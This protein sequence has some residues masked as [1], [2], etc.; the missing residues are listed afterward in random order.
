M[1]LLILS[2]LFLGVFTSETQKLGSSNNKFALQLFNE[3]FSAKKLK[4]ESNILFSP[5]SATAALCMTMLGAEGDTLSQM[6]DV[7]NMN[8]LENPHQVLKN[9]LAE[10]ENTDNTVSIANRLFGNIDF[11]FD[12]SFLD[13]TRDLYGAEMQRVDFSDAEVARGTI[14]D[15]VERKTG[16]KIQNL[17]PEGI[18]SETVALV[19][20]NAIYFQANWTDQFESEW[21]VDRPFYSS[22]RTSTVK[23]MHKGGS[24]NYVDDS[25]LNSEIIEMPFD[26]EVFSYYVILPHKDTHVKT[27]QDSLTHTNIANGIQSL[28]STTVDVALP[29]F[30][31]TESLGLKTIL[32]NM[33][34][35]DLFS[36][37]ADL[38]GIS[39]DDD[40]FVSDVLQKA[41]LKVMYS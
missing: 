6:K 39:N 9:L 19:L 26:G 23:M 33:G 20:T 25:T 32:E 22:G 29:K 14:N 4:D 24:Y 13:D 38:T 5:F 40:L 21:T 8:D 12:Q 2:A 34:M 30:E 1:R 37:N 31:V 16:N 10:I 3:I 18:L 27:L 17:I 28:K 15:W 35:K 36:L 11:S 7:L 41:F